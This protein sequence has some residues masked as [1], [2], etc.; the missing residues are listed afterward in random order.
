MMSQLHF[1]RER[2]CDFDELLGHYASDEFKSPFRSTVPLLSLI[3]DGAG[4]FLSVLAACQVH[5]PADLHLEYTIASPRGTGKPSH[6]DVIVRAG[7]ETLA[8]EA[9]WTEPRYET[10]GKWLK[11][12]KSEDNRRQV[13]AGWLQLL[14]PF[15]PSPLQVD[16]F[17]DA[18]YQMV[19]RAASACPVN[20]HPRLAYV[21]FTPPP[22]ARAATTDQYRDDLTHLHGLLGNP[23]GFPFR[24]VEV[25]ATRTPEFE[26]IALLR[27]GSAET[28]EPVR[29]ALRKGG[30][31]EFALQEV[32]AIP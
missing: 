10:V 4:V 20:K 11:Q 7:D 2:V 23:A 28:S 1:D 31:F 12:G 13:M 32:H 24:L 22:D 14:Q 6:T 21:H 30:L 8:I 3:Q 29:R 16:E 5:E 25:R 26:K 18:I 9:K 17:T 15:A 27:K 19:H